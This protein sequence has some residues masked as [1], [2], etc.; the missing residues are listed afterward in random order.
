MRPTSSGKLIEKPFKSSAW[1]GLAREV[2]GG[3][4]ASPSASGLEGG[5]SEVLTVALVAV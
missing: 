3:V 5:F 1:I 2:Q 4:P